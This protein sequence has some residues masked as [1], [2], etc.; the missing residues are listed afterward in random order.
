MIYDLR[1]EF[2]SKNKELPIII[3]TSAVFRSE[4]NS[5]SAI[6][7]PINPLPELLH[8]DGDRRCLIT[9]WTEPGSQNDPAA[10]TEAR[11]YTHLKLDDFGFVFFFETDA[12]DFQT[13]VFT[14]LDCFALAVN[15]V[16]D[17][18]LQGVFTGLIEGDQ[19][20]GADGK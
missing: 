7:H 20:T 2:V 9:H 18:Q 16:V 1:Q 3:R 19:R 5:I 8:C 15:L 14:N 10:Q 4:K 6:F 13:K 11:F 17:I 12:I